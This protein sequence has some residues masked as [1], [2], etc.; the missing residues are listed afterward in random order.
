MQPKFYYQLENFYA[1]H[2]NFVKSRNY[3]QLRGYLLSGGDIGSTCDPVLTMGSLG[4]SIPKV[5][6]DGTPLAVD[7]VAF[8]CGLIAK[9]FFNDTYIMADQLGNHVTIDETNIAHS[10]D[11]QYK[12]EMP[13]VTS[14]NSVAWL[15]ITNEHVMVWY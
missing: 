12:F 6:L 11:K 7:A 10:V 8:P 4:S 2:R 3:K 13:S 9:Y 14:P 15:N 1:N 5:A